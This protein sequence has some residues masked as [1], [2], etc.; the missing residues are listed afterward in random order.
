MAQKSHVF[1]TGATGYIGGAILHLLLQQPD[2]TVSALVRG[3]ENA[4]KLQSLNVE[5]VLGSLDDTE[6][7]K[8]SSAAAD[9]VIHTANVDHDTSAQAIIDGLRQRGSKDGRKPILIHTSGTAVLNDEPLGDRSETFRTE[10]DL[11]NPNGS[12]ALNAPHRNVDNLVLNESKA[13]DIDIVI[14]CPCMIYGVAEGN[15]FNQ[16]SQQI[17]LT[18]KTAIKEGKT[19]YVGKGKHVWNN[20]HVLDLADFYLLLLRKVQEGK[21]P[22]GTDGYYFCENGENDFI[23]LTNAIASELKKN[24]ITAEPA[25]ADGKELEI[26]GPWARLALGYN[27]RG[28]AE[29]ARS[30][31]WKPSRP[32][33]IETLPEEVKYRVQNK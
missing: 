4:K 25:S 22:L 5:P 18:I 8:K 6:I 24:G 21:A 32:S 26:L 19:Y 16:R 13:G 12:I 20:V 30:L 10:A 27:S 7:I 2:L 3:E 29:K 9:I 15:P 1:I 31:G 28:K 14:I 33:L 17:P 23:E 11:G